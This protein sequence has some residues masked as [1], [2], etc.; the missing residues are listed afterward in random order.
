[1]NKEI[2]QRITDYLSGG[3]LF[4]PE[5]ANHDAVRDLLIDCRDEL[6]KSEPAFELTD[7]G[8]DTNISRGLEPKGS[9]MVT[10]NQV[11]MRV[12]LNDATPRKPWQEPVG[13]FVGGIPEVSQQREWVGLTDE[14]MR[15]MCHND[16]DGDWNDLQQRRVWRETYLAGAKAAQD[17]LKKKNT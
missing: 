9:G 8:A 7:A 3:G 11:G 14:E 16:D 1:M 17:E 10:L 2:V 6:T 4:N 15:L 5:M 13:Q 12:D